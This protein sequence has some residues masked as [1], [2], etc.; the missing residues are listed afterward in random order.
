MCSADCLHHASRSV[1]SILLIL[2]GSAG[3]G[4]AILVRAILQDHA[5]TAWDKTVSP[6]MLYAAMA[7][8]A[9]ARVLCQD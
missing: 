8:F 1:T 3:W 2:A 9:A 4:S 7:W 5:F 6:G